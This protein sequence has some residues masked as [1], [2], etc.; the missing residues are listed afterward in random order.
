MQEAASAKQQGGCK[1]LLEERDSA[2]GRRAGSSQR[3]G[4]SSQSIPA[5]AATQGK[6]NLSYLY[7]T[8]VGQQLYFKLTLDVKG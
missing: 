5:S 1:E 4:N 7:P 6:E 2:L 8:Y 3:K